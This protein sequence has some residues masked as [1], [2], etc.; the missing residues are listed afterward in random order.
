MSPNRIFL[1]ET[2]VEELIIFPQDPDR[3][4]SSETFDLTSSEVRHLEK[5]DCAVCPIRCVRFQLG[6]LA[7]CEVCEN[8]F[9]SQLDIERSK[10]GESCMFTLDTARQI[11]ESLNFVISAVEKW[12]SGRTN[13]LGRWK[14]PANEIFANLV[15]N[16]DNINGTTGS[17]TSIG[18]ALS[19]GSISKKSIPVS[20]TIKSLYPLH[21]KADIVRGYVIMTLRISCLGS[22]IMQKVMFG[23]KTNE[24][25]FTCFK[26]V[27]QE[28]EERFM[29]CVAFDE[30]AH[31]HPVLCTDC[32]IPK[33][34]LP[35]P[36]P[37]SVSSKEEI[38]SPYD[39]YTAEMNGNAI[40]I[41]VEKD[42]QLKVMLP[43][44][45]DDNCTKGCWTSLAL[46]E[47]VYALEERYVQREENACRLPVVRG[48]LKYPA[49]QWSGDF[50]M[51]KQK[52]PICAEDFRV[53]PDQTRSVCMQT[54]DPEK[55]VEPCGIEICRKGW[56][57]PN[58]DVFVL[59]LGKNK[60]SRGE[61]AH[62]QVEVELRTPKG[63]MVEK[64]A[65]ETRGVQV[66]EEEFEDFKK[67]VTEEAKKSKKTTKKGKKK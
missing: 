46:P 64:K 23:T 58:V 51:C 16:Y 48:N 56:N 44:E 32:E 43:D 35:G 40:S 34:N 18:T 21:G 53:R 54:R 62:N 42:C 45:P 5:G 39:E 67:P 24:S 1:V 17:S 28:D 20:E 15:S 12:P 50:M 25:G 26:S 13:V 2:V 7:R 29:K 14:Q 9:G 63:P 6:N 55:T 65:K 4:P 41:R 31:P 57:D 49:R 37:G 61:A 36:P 66:I 10:L 47:G 59:K 33:E 3:D 27:D 60:T 22:R 30:V 52:R 11:D 19:E 8:D 38:C